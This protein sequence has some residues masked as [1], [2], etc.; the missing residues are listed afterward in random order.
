MASVSVLVLFLALM[1]L[2]IA[3][4]RFVNPVFSASAMLGHALSYVRGFD[5]NWGQQ[6]PGS[7]ALMYMGL[8]SLR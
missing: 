7:Q 5:R 6:S 4:A 2:L 3:A 1:A 8:S